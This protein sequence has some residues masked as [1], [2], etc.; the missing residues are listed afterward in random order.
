MPGG[1]LIGILGGI[2][3]G[4]TSGEGRVQLGFSSTRNE[5]GCG[6]YRE[7]VSLGPVLH[8]S[9]DF[10]DPDVWEKKKQSILSGK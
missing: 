10:G 8:G 2:E 6:M 3:W 9:E 5:A 1:Q 7:A 4:K